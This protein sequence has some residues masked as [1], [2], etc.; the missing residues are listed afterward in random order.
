MDGND[1]AHYLKDNPRFFEDFADVIVASLALS[2]LG[3]RLR[4]ATK[5]ASQLF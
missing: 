4:A 1:V 2:V 3:Y 5:S